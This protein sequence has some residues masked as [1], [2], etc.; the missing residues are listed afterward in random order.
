MEIFAAAE[1]RK[2]DKTAIKRRDLT[3]GEIIRAQEKER[4]EAKKAVA[5]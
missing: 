5:L 3:K 4:I 1:K 2:N